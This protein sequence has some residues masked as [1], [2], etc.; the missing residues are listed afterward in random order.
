MSKHVVEQ[1]KPDTSRIKYGTD[2]SCEQH[3]MYFLTENAFKGFECSFDVN[4]NVWI[5]K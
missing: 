5:K 1:N 4:G 3:E 2:N